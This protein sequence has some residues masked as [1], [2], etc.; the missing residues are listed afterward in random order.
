MAVKVTLAMRQRWRCIALA[1]ACFSVSLSAVADDDEK[2]HLQAELGYR[3]GL[4]EYYQGDPLAALT[5]LEV[6]K[7][8]T[9]QRLASRSADALAEDNAA[10]ADA[11]LLE[12][13]IRLGY[14]L[15]RSARALLSQLVASPTLSEQGYAE[16]SLYLAQWLYLHQQPDAA[17]R[18]LTDVRGQLPAD[19][20]QQAAY[21][22]Q[23]L[24]A[25]T[26]STSATAEVSYDAGPWQ[27]YL[28]YNQGIAHA[29]AK[30]ADQALTS[31]EQALILLSQG[32][33]VSDD[34][35]LDLLA[36]SA[37]FPPTPLPLAE[38]E[39]TSL[40]DK[41]QL[42][43]ARIYRQQEDYDAALDAYQQ[44]SL[45]GMAA[46]EALFSYGWTAFNAG[47][48]PLSI[49]AWSALAKRGD[50]SA[51]LLQVHLAIAWSYE[52]WGMPGHALQN[53]Q[54][55]SQAYRV[56]L[57]DLEQQ[58]TSLDPE[59]LMQRL[60]PDSDDSWLSEQDV[61]RIA[62]LPRLNELM[63]SQ[64][65]QSMLIDAR[66]LRL[67]R[68]NLLRWQADMDQFN[69]MLEVRELS[70]QA[71]LQALA[72]APPNSEFERLRGERDA[73]A[74]QLNQSM[75]SPKALANDEELAILKRLTRA[76]QTLEKLQQ[77][78]KYAAYAERVRRV[79][80]ALD[81]QLSDDLVARQWQQ[82]KSLKALDNLLRE[83]EQRL[84][85][86]QRIVDEP[87]QQI[88]LQ[89]RVVDA[90]ARLTQQLLAVNTTYDELRQQVFGLVES[91]LQ[92]Q[93]VLVK[94]H[95]AESQL[96]ITRLYEHY[97]KLQQDAIMG[98]PARESSVPEAN[99]PGAEQPAEQGEGV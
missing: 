19:Q 27:P 57:A 88:A 1:M 16:A 62:S 34:S 65:M 4:F 93:Q 89:Q 99:A 8:R 18:V 59:S 30:Q 9:E 85:R 84:A 49:T 64:S 46:A 50:L 41:I 80:G 39:I 47:Q 42:T 72:D 54:Q 87:S 36:W 10:R 69:A 17:L 28:L 43:R 73:L 6:D 70:R 24:Q 35:W 48:Q 5:F 11:R 2:E 77:H 83:S 79:R 22:E 92:R 63:V 78:P 58:L 53:Y 14:G 95:L 60:L 29:Q 81:W 56:V 91:E 96:A 45:E 90:Q 61:I 44:V 25:T 98:K 51:E 74:A 68:N 86:L 67:L 40:Q 37:W 76:E 75:D 82:T 12:A 20:A 33:A 55:A 71:Q 15:H 32:R 26:G 21:L 7:V 52:Q 3:V 38:G 97:L 66:D 31:L 23:L 13:G 94:N